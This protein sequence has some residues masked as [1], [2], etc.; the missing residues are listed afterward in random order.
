MVVVETA[1]AQI[2]RL[3]AAVGRDGFAHP[4]GVVVVG[5]GRNR[6]IGARLAGVHV[7]QG[8]PDRTR[9]GHHQF[10]PTIIQIRIHD[11]GSVDLRNQLPALQ[12]L[13]VG[14]R[15]GRHSR[16]HEYI[17]GPVVLSESGIKQH[18]DAQSLGP[19]ARAAGS[20]ACGRRR[21]LVT[22]DIRIE[23]RP[24]ALFPMAVVVIGIV[25]CGDLRQYVGEERFVFE[26][27]I[28]VHLLHGLVPQIVRLHIVEHPPVD[29]GIGALRR[30]G[31]RRTHGFLLGTPCT[32]ESEEKRKSDSRTE[33][34]NDSFHNYFDLTVISFRSAA[35]FR[36]HGVNPHA[37]HLGARAMQV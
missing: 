32:D 13:L 23:I 8:H 10:L 20:D 11:P 29:L 16:N 1:V 7:V 28:G 30:L 26:R 34:G 17:G 4:H 35:Y 21:I 9:F 24:F 27:I 33:S 36:H 37:S 12:S 25:L 31:R 5:G 18:L 6:N 15:T 2:A 22:P 3:L 19:F 14:R